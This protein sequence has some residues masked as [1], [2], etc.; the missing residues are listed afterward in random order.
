[1]FVGYLINMRNM[2]EENTKAFSNLIEEFSLRSSYVITSGKRYIKT[3]DIERR[4]L[5]EAIIIEEIQILPK[6]KS[7]LIEFEK[8]YYINV[9]GLLLDN[10]N[11]DLDILEPL[12]SNAGLLTLLISKSRITLEDNI[13]ELDFYDKIL[14]QHQ[15]SL[16]QGHDS[17]ELNEYLQ[18]YLLYKIPENSVLQEVSI[19]RILCYLLS[20]NKNQLILRFNDNVLST[21]SELSLMGSSNI[22]FGLLIGCLLSTTYK[23][24]FLEVYKLIERL[25]PI[26]YLKD[27]HDIVSTQLSFIEFSRQLENITSWRPREE[28]AIEKIFAS[29]KE[30]T[31]DYFLDF[32]KSSPELPSFVDHKY[33]YKIR[34]SIVHF[35]ANHEEFVLSDLQWNLLILATLYLID[36]QYSCYQKI[37]QK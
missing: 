24:A 27:F 4:W 36:E 5:K 16:Y 11:I 15:D 26:S 20:L 6:V 21:I 1:M 29:T 25:F 2:I 17:E 35:R 28:D 9:N 32:F 19:K 10:N 34:N 3:T 22:S 37:L 30:T 8:E 33:F 18:P 7:E 31:R 13:N 14:F 23:Q 12:K